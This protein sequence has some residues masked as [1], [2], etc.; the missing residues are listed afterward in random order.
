MFA[1]AQSHRTAEVRRNSASVLHR[2]CFAAALAFS[3]LLDSTT[4]CIMHIT[5]QFNQREMEQIRATEQD[6]PPKT[7]LTTR[8]S[9][10]SSVLRKSI[11]LSFTYQLIQNTVTLLNFSNWSIQKWKGNSTVEKENNNVLFSEFWRTQMTCP[12]LTDLNSSNTFRINCRIDSILL[13][14]HYSI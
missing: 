14:F 4:M 1:R 11:I 5:V 12:W 10:R 13:F 9:H 6:L 8:P 3:V 2:S 7:A